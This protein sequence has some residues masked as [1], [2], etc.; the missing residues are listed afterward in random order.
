VRKVSTGPVP[1]VRT[2]ALTDLTQAWMARRVA[3]RGI[4]EHAPKVV[5]YFSITSALLWPRAGAISVDSIAAENRPGRHGLWQRTVERRRLAE[6]SLILT[7][8][9]RALA[10]LRTPHAPALLVP[11]PVQLRALPSSTAPRDIDAITYAGN[12]DKRRLSLVLE[13]WQ[14]ARRGTETLVVAGPHRGQPPDGG[15]SVG[16]GGT[17]RV[18]RDEFRAL[19]RRARVFVAAPRREDF[20]IAALEALAEGCLLV[21]TASPG[22]YPALEIATALDPRLVGEDIAGAIRV[23]LD[24]PLPDYA[25]RAMKLLEP[26][27]SEAVDRT[28]ARDLLPRLLAGWGAPERARSGSA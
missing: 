15:R 3:R 16:R 28:V 25:E 12:P 10:P 18:R 21:T 22:P 9:A 27:G 2:F 26:F 7:W 13:E 14:R 5:V 19:L 23:A 20:G 6:A 8:S 11:P 24:D 4:A 17:R 1:R